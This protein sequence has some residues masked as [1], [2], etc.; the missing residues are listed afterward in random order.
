M[1]VGQ[2]SLSGRSE[3]VV[4]MFEWRRVGIG[5]LQEVRYRAQGTKVFGGEEKYKF[6]WS[7]SVEGRNGVGIMVKED[8]VVEVFE[9]KRLN[10][11]VMTIALKWGRKILYVFSVYALQQ[12]GPE[13]EKREFLEKLSD[14]IH[15]I[16]EEDLLMVLGDM[17]CYIGSTRDGLRM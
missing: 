15:D 11:R 3:G 4:D 7:G 6:C 13:K 14:N 12:G 5:C 2:G 9:V 10:D 17:N 1:N 16:P 8:L